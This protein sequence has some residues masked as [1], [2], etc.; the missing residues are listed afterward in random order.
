[1]SSVSPSRT[2]ERRNANVCRAIWAAASLLLSGAASFANDSTAE[3]VTGGLKFARSADIEMRSEDLFVSTQQIRVTY[4]FF[5][6]SNADVTELVA[7]P[8][9][10]ITV[11]NPDESIAVPT[12]DPENI[13]GFATKV[14]GAPVAAKVEQ[15]VLS[16]GVDHTALLRQL[17]V[18]LEPYLEVTNKALDQLPRDKWPELIKL[19]LADT[20][21]EDV[22]QGNQTHLEARWTLKTTYYWR[23]TFPAAKELTIEHTYKP[24]VGSSAVALLSLSAQDPSYREYIAKYCVDR[25]FIASVDAAKSRDRFLPTEQRISYILRTGANWAGPIRDFR[26]I[27]DKGDPSALV[28]FC[29]QGVKKISPTQFEIRHSNFTPQTDLNILLLTRRAND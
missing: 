7:F 24:S 19:G 14:D 16:R 6:R 22:G 4:R 11:S 8:M 18:P 3:L 23:Q 13:L 25:D 9:P 1:M 21:D 29:A 20:L 12:D 5:N 27:V 28:S 17:G 26:L 10:D 15:K 2:A